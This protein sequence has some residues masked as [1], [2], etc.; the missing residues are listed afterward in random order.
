V[1]FTAVAVL[2]AIVAALAAAIALRLLIGRW[3]LGWLRGTAG[4][5]LTILAVAIALSAWDLR[6]YRPLSAAEPVGTISFS[7]LGPQ[8]F[9]ATLTTPSGEERRVELN[10]DMW[11]IDVRLLRWADALARLGLKPGYRLDRLGGRYLSLED[12]QSRPRSVIGL[13]EMRTAFDVWAWLRRS[14]NT[15]GVL[16]ADYGSA[17]YLPMA[18]GALY[19]IGLGGDGLV[20]TPLNDPARAAIE[21]WE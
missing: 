1:L 2:L 14:G 13:G 11:Q 18:D 19:Q 12:E 9:A 16:A 4:I 21:Q 7:Q 17:T 5:A 15:L 10:G 6:G 8:H 20:A 3:L